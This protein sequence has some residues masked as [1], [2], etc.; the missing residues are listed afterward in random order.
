MRVKYPSMCRI[1]GHGNYVRTKESQETTERWRRP[2]R[3]GYRIWCRLL[4]TAG[5][6][7]GMRPKKAPVHLVRAVGLVQRLQLKRELIPMSLER[8]DLKRIHVALPGLVDQ[9]G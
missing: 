5:R 8:G 4:Q 7:Y 6:H 2:D 3:S 1:P 9:L